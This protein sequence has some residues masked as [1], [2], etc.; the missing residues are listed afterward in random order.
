MDKFAEELYESYLYDIELTEGS[1]ESY[2]SYLNGICNK[3]LDPLAISLQ[4]PKDQPFGFVDLFFRLRKD[5]KLKLL[6]IANNHIRDAKKNKSTAIVSGTLSNYYSGFKAFFNMA[7]LSNARP[8]RSTLDKDYTKAAI[9]SLY[10]SIGEF[11]FSKKMLDG[12][13]LSR[14]KTQE[15]DYGTY[16]FPM[17]VIWKLSTTD[18]ALNE[19][20]LDVMKKK[21]DEMIYYVSS[22]GK[23]TVCHSDISYIVLSNDEGRVKIGK[24]TLY[25]PTRNNDFQKQVPLI[26]QISIDHLHCMKDLLVDNIA[27]YPALAKLSN[28]MNSVLAGK[29]FGRNSDKAK[30]FMKSSVCENYDSAFILSL[31]D[32]TIDI[33]NRMEFV[34]MDKRE[35]SSKNDK[36]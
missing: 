34:A 23:Q 15:R 27:S 5:E 9:D 11:V 2:K 31:V 18:K 10:D 6:M 13:Y 35:N 24:K 4:N 22:D 26:D 33:H 1:V 16:R 8:I 20:L 30:F 28:D 3:L 32:E 19:N 17:R 25:T 12:I 21:I 36:I 29:K 14:L 7:L